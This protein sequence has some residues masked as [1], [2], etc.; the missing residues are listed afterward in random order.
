MQYLKKYVFIQA[1]NRFYPM[2]LHTLISFIH[3]FPKNIHKKILKI[4]NLNIV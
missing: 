3:W 2:E 4:F 1:P